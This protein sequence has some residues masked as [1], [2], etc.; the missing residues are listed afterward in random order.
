MTWGL[1]VECWT[2]NGTFIVVLRVKVRPLRMPRDYKGNDTWL[3]R[4][5]FNYDQIKSQT[6]ALFSIWLAGRP[7]FKFRSQQRSAVVDTTDV[8]TKAVR[9]YAFTHIRKFTLSSN[10][11][12][13]S[14]KEN[15]FSRPCSR[16]CFL[17]FY[18]ISFCYFPHCYPNPA[19][20][21]IE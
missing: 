20:T 2:S 5:F 8:L 11:Q 16:T 13:L 7:G 21:P 17:V 10:K 12:R 9:L 4:L 1:N 3:T 6:I 15:G 19:T 18:N 14:L